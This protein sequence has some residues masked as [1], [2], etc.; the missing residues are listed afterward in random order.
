MSDVPGGMS[1]MQNSTPVSSFGTR[2]EVVTLM[3]HTRIATVTPTR[4]N[5]V[6]LWLINHVVPFL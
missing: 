3:S 4:E 6:I 5:D 1:S 2:V